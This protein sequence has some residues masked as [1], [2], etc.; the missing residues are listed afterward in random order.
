MDV[1]VMVFSK[2]LNFD[3]FRLCL[4]NLYLDTKFTFENAKFI[5]AENGA[6]S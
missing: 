4:Q 3:Y 5:T 2:H 1:A 6:I